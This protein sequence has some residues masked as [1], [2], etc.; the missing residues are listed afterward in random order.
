MHWLILRRVPARFVPVLHFEVHG[1]R[2]GLQLASGEQ[3]EWEDLR[4]ALT[5]INVAT[6]D[7][8]LLCLAACHGAHAIGLIDVTQPAPFCFLLAPV[9]E[10]WNLP[11][12]RG[13][14]AFYLRL[15]ETHSAN[16]A[17]RA[18]RDSHAPDECEFEAI[19]SKR[20]FI[21]VMARELRESWDSAAKEARIHRIME[22]VAERSPGHRYDVSMRA[23][24]REALSF[25]EIERRCKGSARIFFMVGR[26]PDVYEVDAIWPEV[27]EAALQPNARLPRSQGR[28]PTQPG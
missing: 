10:V 13:F 6:G 12:L 24:A 27:L 19:S 28:E 3:V 18:M 1:T 17:M 26:I 23:K 15:L 9:D 4:A 11:T 5:E 7:R 21:K 25:S 2:E 22:K 16:E 8:V 14:E 20:F